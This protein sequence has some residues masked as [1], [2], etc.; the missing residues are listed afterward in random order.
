M[1]AE[2]NVTEWTQSKYY[3]HGKGFGGHS[4]AVSHVHS[5]PRIAGADVE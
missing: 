4:S 5:A 2:A 1:P 3:F